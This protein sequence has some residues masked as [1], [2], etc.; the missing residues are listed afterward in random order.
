MRPL[1]ASTSWSVASTIAALAFWS[2][3]PVSRVFMWP[4]AMLTLISP[5]V[6]SANTL[7]ICA[8]PPGAAVMTSYVLAAMHQV[9]RLF[10]PH[11]KLPRQPRPMNR[12]LNSSIGAGLA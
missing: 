12:W 1:A 3:D 6:P 4:V 7:C 8:I 10:Q 9:S 5:S 2:T 11:A